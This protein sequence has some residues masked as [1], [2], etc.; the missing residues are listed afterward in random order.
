MQQTI[1]R[2]EENGM[3]TCSLPLSMPRL[4]LPIVLFRCKAWRFRAELVARLASRLV[5]STSSSHRAL[6]EKQRQKNQQ[7]LASAPE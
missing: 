1:D 5:R 3:C 6:Y 7:P 2:L 4:Q